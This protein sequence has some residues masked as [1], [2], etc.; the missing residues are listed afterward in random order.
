MDK[1]TPA[2]LNQNTVTFYAFHHT[3]H[4]IDITPEKK[5]NL[6]EILVRIATPMDHRGEP[7]WR[8]PL[9]FKK[10]RTASSLALRHQPHHSPTSLI[11]PFSNWRY[12]AFQPTPFGALLLFSF[13]SSL[14]FNY[15]RFAAFIYAPTATLYG[16]LLMR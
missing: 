16:P 5:T 7:E 2:L 13:F 3:D 1:S 14:P 11:D 9:L 6:V 8:A 12:I 10:N 4:P 15:L